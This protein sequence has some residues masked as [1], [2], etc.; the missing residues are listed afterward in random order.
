MRLF[1]G[2]LGPEVVRG[3]SAVDEGRTS[4]F[5]CSVFVQKSD[6][7]YSWLCG[8]GSGVELMFPPDMRS[9][10]RDYLKN[11]IDQYNS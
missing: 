3:G 5:K 6:Q 1:L 9:E 10:F 4:S 7:F 2:D 8:F 11:V